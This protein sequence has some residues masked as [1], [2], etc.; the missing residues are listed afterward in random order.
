LFTCI[1]LIH[2]RLFQYLN[3][4]FY[5]NT[6]YRFQSITRVK[7]F[8]ISI[9]S[10]NRLDSSL[11]SLWLALLPKKIESIFNNTN[12]A[13]RY[14]GKIDTEGADTRRFD[15]SISKQYIENTDASL[16]HARVFFL[17]T[18]VDR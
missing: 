12:W 7:S 17:S 4:L 15:I 3:L 11:N 16:T 13:W 10:I 8:D 2:L 14:I 1:V 18:T 9:E 6:D 5:S